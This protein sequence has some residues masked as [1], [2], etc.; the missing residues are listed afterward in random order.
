M[1]DLSDFIAFRTHISMS[2]GLGHFSR[3]ENLEHNLNKKVIW[4]LT[5]DRNLIKKIFKKKKFFF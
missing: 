5:G 2:V 4:F 1:I 3:I